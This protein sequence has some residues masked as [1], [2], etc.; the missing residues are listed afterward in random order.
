MSGPARTSLNGKGKCPEDL[1]QTSLESSSP[2]STRASSPAGGFRPAL[3][4]L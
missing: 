3:L 4:W 1:C 2:S